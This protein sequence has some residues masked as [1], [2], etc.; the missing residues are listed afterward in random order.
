MPIWVESDAELAAGR[1]RGMIV[2]AH[3]SGQGTTCEFFII[4]YP[5][6]TYDHAKHVSSV[7]GVLETIGWAALAS[8]HEGADGGSVN[9]AL[10]VSTARSGPERRLWLA[11][12]ANAA[13]DEG[14]T[15]QALR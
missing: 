14:A 9:T 6:D 7:S 1:Q 10:L 5:L 11:E 3:G 8:W 15:A 13:Q 12:P 2:V 4:F